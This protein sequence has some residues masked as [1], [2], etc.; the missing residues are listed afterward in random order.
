MAVKPAPLFVPRLTKQ[1]AGSLDSLASKV[2]ENLLLLRD[3]LGT[4]TLNVNQALTVLNVT[5]GST[6]PTTGGMSFDFTSDDY[7][8]SS[9]SEGWCDERV[10]DFPAATSPNLSLTIVAMCTSSSGAGTLRVRLGGTTRTLNGS[11]AASTL[12]FGTNTLVKLQVTVPN[13][14]AVGLLKFS[15][16][17]SAG[18]QTARIHAISIQ[19]R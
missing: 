18:G 16:Q 11:V 10:C 19:V 9:G 14:G 13:P 4:L 1:S 7:Q 5:T 3:R 8:N 6:A 17:A 12:F 15:V 2:D